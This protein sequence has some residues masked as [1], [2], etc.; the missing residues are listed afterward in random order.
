LAVAA[1]NFSKSRKLSTG[2]DRARG[3]RFLL[4]VRVAGISQ[5]L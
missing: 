2:A 5:A 1:S 3:S 4:L